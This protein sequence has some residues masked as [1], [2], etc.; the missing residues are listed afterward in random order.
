MGHIALENIQRVFDCVLSYDEEKIAQVY[1]TEKTIN[2]METLITEYLVKISNLALNEDQHTMINNLFYS[3]SDIE[4]VGDHAENIAELVDSRKE[5][6]VPFSE[7]ALNDLK[8]IMTTA[9]KAFACSIKAREE[10]SLAEANKVA[11]YED[12]VDTM[13]EELREKHI[14][15]LSKQLCDPTNGVI[16]LDIIS[17]LERISDHAYNLAGYVMSER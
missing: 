2:N 3:V 9:G 15:R 11:K 16:F 8:E 14:S 13:E 5:N 10:M 6:P 7:N 1:K 12:E 4:R 17:N